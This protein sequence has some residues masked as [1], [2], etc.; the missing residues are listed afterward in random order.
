MLP[1]VLAQACVTVLG[2]SGAGIS[3][4]LDDLRVPLGSSDQLAACAEQ[5]QVTLGE[6]PCLDALGARRPQVFDPATMADRWPDF[7]A[8]VVRL[9][10]FRAF[11]SL[12]ILP[13]DVPAVGAVDLYAISGDGLD[14]LAL[15]EVSAAIVPTIAGCLFEEPRVALDRGTLLPLWLGNDAVTHRMDVWIAV[16][17]VM[18]LAQLTRNDALADLRSY[19]R[20]HEMTLDEVA[21]QIAEGRLS[22]ELVLTERTR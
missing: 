9:T 8:E 19:A 12:P 7:H 6:G 21:F 20:Q 16:G 4:M 10:P 13:I 3:M 15:D 1:D 14:E 17:T 22:A 5:L 11:A 18:D 2:V